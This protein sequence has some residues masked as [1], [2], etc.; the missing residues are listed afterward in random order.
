MKNK[1]TWR[2]TDREIE[3]LHAALANLDATIQFED[4]EIQEIFKKLLDRLACAVDVR[5][6]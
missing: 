1:Q 6:S 4:A 2:F 3:I 5:N